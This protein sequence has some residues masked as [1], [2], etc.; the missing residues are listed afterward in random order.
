MKGFVK[1]D[2]EVI[3]VSISNY[4]DKE[5]LYYDELTRA[6]LELESQYDELSWWDRFWNDDSRTSRWRIV[7]KCKRLKGVYSIIWTDWL[8]VF[9]D[10]SIVSE[11]TYKSLK[12]TRWWVEHH[13]SVVYEL[14]EMSKAGNE[15]FLSPMQAEFVNDY[16]DN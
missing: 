11:E 8:T 9:K 4:K 14:E 2:R 12:V 15:I 13:S 7:A 10:A 5:K 3:E 16:K 6:K 1:V